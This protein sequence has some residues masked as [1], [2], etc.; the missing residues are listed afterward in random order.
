MSLLFSH[1]HGPGQG[2]TDTTGP[3]G[4]A[5]YLVDWRASLR[6][7]ERACCCPAKPAVV[8][9]MP[10]APDRPYTVDLL[11]CHHHYRVSAR[12]LAAAGAA[13]LGTDGTPLTEHTRSL[14]RSGG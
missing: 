5:G 13:V 7:A 4:P 11:L 8:V 14:V 10:A 6:R 1:T 3:P 2:G 12:A 9:I